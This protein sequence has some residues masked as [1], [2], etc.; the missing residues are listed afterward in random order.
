M[1]LF[2]LVIFLIFSFNLISDEIDFSL[3]NTDDKHLINIVNKCSGDFSLNTQENDKINLVV[4]HGSDLNFDCLKKAII[5]HHSEHKIYGETISIN[6][7]KFPDTPLEN[8]TIISIPSIMTYS[9]AEGCSV[10]EDY[11]YIKGD[12]FWLFSL[13]SVG[14]GFSVEISNNKKFALINVNSMNGSIGIV[15]E[16]YKDNNLYI[17]YS[18]FLSPFEGNSFQE[19]FVWLNLGGEDHFQDLKSP[20]RYVYSSF[21]RD[22]SQENEFFRYKIISLIDYEGENKSCLSVDY[23]EN[24][25]VTFNRIIFDAITTLMKD[26]GIKEYCVYEP[27]P[28][29][30]VDNIDEQSFPLF[31][32]LIQK[33]SLKPP[34]LNCINDNLHKTYNYNIMVNAYYKCLISQN[35]SS[36]EIENLDEVIDF[37]KNYKS[38]TKFNEKDYVEICKYYDDVFNIYQIGLRRIYYDE[39]CSG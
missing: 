25:D 12:E 11:L 17:T 31:I 13:P 34:F 7:L 21:V 3:L 15:Y 10:S 39:D 28:I 33:Y 29:I 36:L 38:P 5:K 1:K 24:T 22:I 19:K 35:K 32:T 37:Y 4:F 23:L 6:D 30:N 27:N 16:F 18:G 9:C 20:T 8:E 14:Y 26:N 2:Y